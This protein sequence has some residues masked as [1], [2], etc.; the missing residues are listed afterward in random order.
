LFARI[1]HNAIRHDKE[2]GGICP[3]GSVAE[4]FAVRGF[5]V[6]GFVYTSLKTAN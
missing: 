1:Q 3:R 5:D 4:E 6:E 2:V